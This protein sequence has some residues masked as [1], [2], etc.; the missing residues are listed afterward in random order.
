MRGQFLQPHLVIMQ[1]PL[2]RIIYEH[3]RSYVHRVYQ[4]EP[5]LDFA[6]M[7]QVSYRLGNIYK[8]ASIRHF[9]PKVL[10]KAFHTRLMPSSLADCNN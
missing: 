6:L 8:T 5:L 10:R 2:L 1:E 4:A 9:E 3:G 7:N